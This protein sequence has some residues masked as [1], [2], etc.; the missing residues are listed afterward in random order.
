M[1]NI[2]VPMR[3]KSTCP[4]AACFAGLEALRE[5]KIAVR[6]VPMLSPRIMGIAASRVMSPCEA[7]AMVRPIVAAE[8]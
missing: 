2:T 7:T 1:R 6:V 5:A 8:D 4:N 3:L